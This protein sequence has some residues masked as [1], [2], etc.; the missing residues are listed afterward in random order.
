MSIYERR[1][2]YLSGNVSVYTDDVR[3]VLDAIATKGVTHV[4]DGY[5]DYKDVPDGPGRIG[6]T[7]ITRRTDRTL[8]ADEF[9]AEQSLGAF[10]GEVGEKVMNAVEDG[11]LEILGNRRSNRFWHNEAEKVSFDVTDGPH[12][13]T[14]TVAVKRDPKR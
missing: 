9:V 13:V 3:E 12:T 7:L 11:K 6:G 8:T 5:A 14:V 2:N 4:S 10:V 1:W